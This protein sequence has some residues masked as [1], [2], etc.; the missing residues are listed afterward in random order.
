M[1]KYRLDDLGWYQFE[2]LVQSVL[3]ARLGLGVESWG[4]SHDQGRDAFFEGDL[5]FPVKGQVS[6]GPFLFQV[7]FVAGAN[8]AGAKPEPLLVSAVRQEMRD[9]DLRF[10]RGLSQYVLLTNVRITPGLRTRVVG[11]VQAALPSCGIAVVGG[12]D[13]CDWLDQSPNVRISFPQILG[14]HDLQ[15]LLTKAVAKQVLERSTLAVDEAREIASVFV[16]TNAYS[17]TLRVL[18]QHHFVVLEG[19]PE[20]GKTAIARMVGL[21]QLS[22][23]WHA[24][25]C[26]SPTEFFQVLSRD[27]PQ[28]FIADDAF[29]ST[30]YDPVRS[31]AWAYDLDRVLRRVDSE[32]W[33][34]WTARKHILSMALQRMRLQGVAEA[35]PRPGSVLVNVGRMTATEKALILYRHAKSEGLE[36]QAREIVRR[37][38]SM[39][40]YNRHFTPERARRFVKHG[41]PRLVE[42]LSNGNLNETAV[43][44]EIGKEIRDPTKALR[45]SF[46]ALPRD[47]RRLLISILDARQ[48]Y[49]WPSKEGVRKAYERHGAADGLAPFDRVL[50]ELSE[51]FLTI[52]E[53]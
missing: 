15:D 52:T 21:L 20:V 42:D 35:F 43:S 50:E 29:G 32:H 24:F 49:V 8:A 12:Q 41:L 44:E 17:E 19:P 37:H 2:W 34:I 51:A 40:V 38:A 26:S 22:L 39:I 33:F 6:K 14:L 7:K 30:E 10:G 23:G 11:E 25:E 28:V 31:H 3:K 27:T 16:P 9:A 5:E 45:Q 36:Q 48:A 1:L 18:R 13:I 4:G 46:D 53:R 47:H